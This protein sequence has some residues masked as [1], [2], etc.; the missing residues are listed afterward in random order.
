MTY[1]LGGDYSDLTSLHLGPRPKPAPAPPPLTPEQKTRS[2]IAGLLKL[3]YLI[4]AAFTVL[5]LLLFVLVTSTI[6]IALAS[7]PH[8][9]AQVVA[10]EIYSK[11]VDTSTPENGAAHSTVYGFR[12]TVSYS[13]ASHPYQSKAD[14]GYQTGNE[15][16][17]AAWQSRI[18]AGDQIEIA[19]DPTAPTHIRLAGDFTTAYAPAL[20]LLHWIAWLA[21]IAALSKVISRNLRP[22]TPEDIPSPVLSS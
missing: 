18:Q 5:L 4:C 1:V 19:Y 14:I 11:T 12:C 13:V 20:M 7:N 3:L 8:T 15:R 6:F 2:T 22:P 9:Q 10:T 16:A 17:M 21:A